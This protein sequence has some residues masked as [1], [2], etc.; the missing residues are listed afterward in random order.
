MKWKITLLSAIAMICSAGLASANDRDTMLV[1]PGSDGHDNHATYR[2]VDVRTIIGRHLWTTIT[3]YLNPCPNVACSLYSDGVSGPGDLLN[4]GT[5]FTVLGAIDGPHGI[6]TFAQVRLDDGRAGFLL[7]GRWSTEDPKITMDHFRAGLQH[8]T[9]KID[10]EFAAKRAE[11]A[12]YWDHEKICAAGKPEIGMTKDEAVKAWCQ[13][14]HINTDQT[15][16]GVR[17]QWVYGRSDYI[18][19]YLYF[20]NGRLVAIQRQ[21]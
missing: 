9:A 3:G 1:T 19:G 5:G 8:G 7:P 20:E 16:F 18:R 6:T 11:I 15:A 12:A 4:P 17:E 10:A 2:Q 21:N 13:P 14:W